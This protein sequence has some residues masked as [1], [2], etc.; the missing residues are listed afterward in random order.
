MRLSFSHIHYY[1][2]V[3]DIACVIQYRKYRKYEG[4]DG[5]GKVKS[6]QNLREKF[7]SFLMSLSND[8]CPTML[9]FLIFSNSIQ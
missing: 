9:V 4:Q 6:F 5:N 8:M 3:V 1:S 7:P 2:Y